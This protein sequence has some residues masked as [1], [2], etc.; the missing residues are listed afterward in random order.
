MSPLTAQESPAPTQAVSVEVPASVAGPTAERQTDLKNLAVNATISPTVQAQAE[1]A[2][3]DPWKPGRWTFGAG[4][5]PIVGLNTEFSGVGHA[6]G[7]PPPTGGQNY[8]YLDGFVRV[9]ASG[10]A[11]GDTTFWAY[12]RNSPAVGNTIQF[13]SL[14]GGSAAG[15]SGATDESMAAAAAFE[16]YGY[17]DLGA[18]SLFPSME[19]NGATWGLRAGLHYGYVDH[20]S[21]SAYSGR[22]STVIDSFSLGGIGAPGGGFIGTFNGPN[23]LLSDTP[24]RVLGSG[25]T[26]VQISGSRSLEVHLTMSQW[27][28]YLNLPLNEKLDLRLEGGVILALASG[29]YRYDNRVRASG[30]ATSAGQRSRGSA[31]RTMILPGFYAGASLEYELTER[32]S[33][34]GSLRYQFLKHFEINTGGTSAQLAFNSAFVLGVGA[35]WRF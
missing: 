13:Q 22:A 30:S 16:I 28:S 25:S 19:K 15:S 1:A 18:A 5:A 6:T 27:G 31:S 23:Q 9:D 10:N 34:Q 8:E 33:L 2:A 24:T 14:S 3:A 11:G 7:L 4:Y 20:D 35:T 26:A 12:D 17:Y 29:E 32:L 21:D